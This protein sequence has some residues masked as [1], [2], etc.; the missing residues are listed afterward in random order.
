MERY[1]FFSGGRYQR[2][3]GLLGSIARFALPILKSLGKNA[4]RH[5]TRALANTVSDALDQGG[6]LKSAALKNTVQAAKDTFRDT[7]TQKGRGRKRT[8][9]GG[10][11]KRRPNTDIFTYK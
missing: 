4:L 1:P 6:N 2:G 11:I 3:N 10:I 8:R 9:L 7:I 5:G